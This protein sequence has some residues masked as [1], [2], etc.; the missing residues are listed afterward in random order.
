[1]RRATGEAVCLHVTSYSLTSASSGIRTIPATQTLGFYSVSDF[2]PRMH[3][4]SY[5]HPRTKMPLMASFRL[6]FICKCHSHGSGNTSTAR[7]VTT[8]A[9]VTPY[10]REFS[11]M[12]WPL[13]TVLSQKKWTG[14]QLKIIERIK[15][16]HHA[17]VATPVMIDM[18]VN[19]LTGNSR[20]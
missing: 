9:A 17:I 13:W 12:Q 5:K 3:T 16:K 6:A 20:L 8:F 15:A 19:R 2:S 7:S 4:G 11:L 14:V 18:I 1:M 10:E